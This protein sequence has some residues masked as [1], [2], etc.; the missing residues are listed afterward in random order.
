MQIAVEYFF[1]FMVANLS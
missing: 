1:T